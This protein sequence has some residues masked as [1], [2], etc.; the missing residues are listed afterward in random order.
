MEGAVPGR[1]TNAS[2]AFANEGYETASG[3]TPGLFV[4][5]D[6]RVAEVFWAA[7][8]QMVKMLQFVPLF[9][10][11][12]RAAQTY[13]VQA[14]N[15]I[16]APSDGKWGQVLANGRSTLHQ[17]QGPHAHKLVNQTISGN[18]SPVIDGGVSAQQRA[19]R[20]NR[21]IPD[22]DVVSEMAMGH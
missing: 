22:P 19:I 1:L 12:A 14:T 11:I 15:S 20:D 6:Q 2:F 21:P 7:E 13:H 4:G 17:G 18:E 9:R 10:R 8:K 3:L 5:F 16:V